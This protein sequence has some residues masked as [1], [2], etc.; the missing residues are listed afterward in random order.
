MD[1]FHQSQKWRNPALAQPSQPG[2]QK[3]L[4]HNAGNV[5]DLK[6]S[7]DGAKIFFTVGRSRAEVEN[8]LEKEARAGYLQQEPPIYTVM[9]GALLPSCTDGKKSHLDVF[10]QKEREC[11]LTHWVYEIKSGRERL[12]TEAEVRDIAAREDSRSARYGQGLRLGENVRLKRLS[13]DGKQ[14]AW[15]EKSN[16]DDSGWAPPMVVTAISENGKKLRCPAEA[17][18]AKNIRALWWAATGENG[19]EEIIFRVNDGRNYTLSSFYGWT[20]GENNLRTILRSNDNISQCELA[21]KRLVCG[22]ETWTSPK[23]IVSLDLDNGEITPII[24]VN[25]AFQ[26]FKFT[27]VEKIFTK[28]GEGYTVHGHLVY[29]RDYQKGKRYPL[30]IVETRSAS[31]FLRG[32]TGDEQPVHVYAQQGMAVLSYSVNTHAISDVKYSDLLA[33][34]IAIDRHIIIKQAYSEAI[35][36][37][38]AALD[39]RGIIDPEKIGISGLSAGSVVTDVALLN[40]NYAAA[41]T[42]YSAVSSRYPMGG[43]DSSFMR[44]VRN[45]IFDGPQSSPKGAEM[46]RKYSVDSNA[47]RIDTPYLIQV[48]DRE[49]NFAMANY[50]ALLETGKPV[51]MYIYPDEYHVKWQPTHKYM[52]YRRNLDWFNFWLRGVED[53]APEKVAQYQRW[54]KL[55][56]L[57]LTNLKEKEKRGK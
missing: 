50:N 52:V 10:Y 2:G 3:Q 16:P 7:T 24:D 31:T 29:P 32:G 37:M 41:S 47:K 56:E 33:A 13:A 40:R 35:E 15:I 34:Q 55:R 51:E 1:I 54:R 11:R 57:Y 53:P 46:R 49:V 28:D 38:I 27:T 17:C 30:V 26:N 22:Q 9:Q 43:I 45:T 48:A 18:T 20:S 12:A 19:K 39:K 8:L 14:L 23:K 21:G 4:T 42:A 44:K 25:P 5:R 6:S 36:N